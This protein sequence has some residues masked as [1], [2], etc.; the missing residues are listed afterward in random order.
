MQEDRRDKALAPLTYESWGAALTLASKVALGGR[1][2]SEDGPG[3]TA[4]VCPTSWT[5]DRGWESHARTNTALLPRAGLQ[6]PESPGVGRQAG[7]RLR[8]GSAEGGRDPAPRS[9]IQ[10]R[11]PT[12][13]QLAAQARRPVGFSLGHQGSLSGRPRTEGLRRGGQ[14]SLASCPTVAKCPAHQTQHLPPAFAFN[15]TL[16]CRLT[17]RRTEIPPPESSSAPH[18]P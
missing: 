7:S 6:A 13:P 11:R 8:V 5:R 1:P 4:S 9:P 18:R 14:W 15:E 2:V 10:R 3:G 17:T 12:S 16:T